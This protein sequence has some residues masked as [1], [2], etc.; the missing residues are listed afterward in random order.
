MVIQDIPRFDLAHLS[1]DSVKPQAIPGRSQIDDCD[2][3][4]VNLDGALNTFDV[5]QL[6]IFR[7]NITVHEVINAD[8]AH[9]EGASRVVFVDCL[10]EGGPAQPDG[11]SAMGGWG[12]DALEVTG[13]SKVTLAGTTV[14]GGT[15]QEV[16]GSSEP[17]EG[18]D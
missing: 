1:P 12:G 10:I 6:V 9:V 11:A 17:A 4:D 7:S 18:R 14:R 5:D 16:V 3:S 15:G 13:Q 2:V 8:A